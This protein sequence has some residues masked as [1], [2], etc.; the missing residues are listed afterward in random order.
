MKE[1]L[2]TCINKP[3]RMSSHEHITH[4]G[5]ITN[6]PANRWRLAREEAIRRIEA[7]EEAFYTVDRATGNKMYIASSGRQVRTL[8]SAHMQTA[9]GTTICWHKLNV[10]ER[11]SCSN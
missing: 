6:D 5:N 10:T 4:I 8:S 3:N 7:K 9:N 2:V 11:A 1:F